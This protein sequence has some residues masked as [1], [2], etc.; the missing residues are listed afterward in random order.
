MTL[1]ERARWSVGYSLRM[2]RVE[3][4]GLPTDTNALFRCI[5]DA[6]EK[7]ASQDSSHVPETKMFVII[8]D[9]LRETD[10]PPARRSYASP[11]RSKETPL[12]PFV[13]AKP[14]PSISRTIGEP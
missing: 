14:F 3:F 6:G 5:H 4:L 9:L 13:I 10:A 7:W 12:A 1:S 2:T 8:G 11:P